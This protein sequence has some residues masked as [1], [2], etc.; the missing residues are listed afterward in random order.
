MIHSC[1]L[2]IE[3]KLDEIGKKSL[4]EQAM[5]RVQERVEDIARQGKRLGTA[6]NVAT[7]LE[8]HMVFG[9]SDRLRMLLRL[10][11]SDA[12]H[13]QSADTIRCYLEKVVPDR[14]VLGHMVLAPEGRPQSVVNIEGRE[15][16]LDN[17]RALRKTILGLRE[18]FRT[19]VDA[20]KA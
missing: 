13:A 19:L 3:A 10:L 1:V 18:D 14:N 15:I 17:M 9:A 2:H 8:A 16:S 7:I 20:L 4:V 11:E 5:V 6:T 12:I